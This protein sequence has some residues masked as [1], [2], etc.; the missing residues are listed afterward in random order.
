M[1][2][3]KNVLLKMIKYIDLKTLIS[4]SNVVNE[5]ID[6]CKEDIVYLWN[7]KVFNHFSA[8]MF[9][10]SEVEL[11]S[12]KSARYTV[13]YGT[14][15]VAVI[16]TES[17]CLG[18]QIGDGE[19]VTINED[20]ECSQP[21]P[22]D[23]RCFLNETTSLCDEKPIESFRHFFIKAVE[24]FPCGIFIGSDGVDGCFSNEEQL[25][26]LYKTMLYSFGTA[27]FEEAVSELKEY[28]PRLSQ[29]GSKDDISIAAII[30]FN[31]LSNNEKLIQL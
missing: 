25:Y 16:Q 30:D 6:K 9:S 2:I 5:F 1:E 28:L 12:K 27:E 4:D 29:K 11:L 20:G 7:E 23:E 10:S 13:A 24:D 19:C 26:K 31:K 8:N 15:L 3:A 18:L 22:S 21:F 17:F 14:T